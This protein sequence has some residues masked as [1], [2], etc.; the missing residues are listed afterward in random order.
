[1]SLAN[2]NLKF[3]KPDSKDTAVLDTFNR[4]LE[5]QSK[6]VRYKLANLFKQYRNKKRTI[7]KKASEKGYIVGY[8]KGSKDSQ[9]SFNTSTKNIR[10]FK[11]YLEQ[12]AVSKALDIIQEILPSDKTAQNRVIKKVIRELK[13][14]LKDLRFI[15]VKRNPKSTL[16]T[17]LLDEI[18]FDHVPVEVDTELPID[19]LVLITPVGEITLCAKAAVRKDTISIINDLASNE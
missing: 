6:I 18:Q 1:M 14:R 9:K 3:K 10:I 4:V 8:Q 16:S 15:K 2:I 11:K 17:T 12:Y 13:P 5:E 19:Y 7:Y